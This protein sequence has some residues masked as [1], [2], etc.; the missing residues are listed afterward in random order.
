MVRV[1]GARVWREGGARVWEDVCGARAA[2]GGA[3]LT[4]LEGEDRVAEEGELDRTAQAD[5]PTAHD[6]D[7]EHGAAGL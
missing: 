2:L 6:E 7:A 4:L 1:C 3:V 5:R